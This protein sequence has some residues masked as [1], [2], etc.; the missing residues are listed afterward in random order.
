MAG[1]ETCD[2]MANDGRE[3]D[4]ETEAWNSTGRYVPLLATI[5]DE[6]AKKTVPLSHRRNEQKSS[7]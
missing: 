2:G 4:C 5:N 1:N 3:R 7:G 6:S